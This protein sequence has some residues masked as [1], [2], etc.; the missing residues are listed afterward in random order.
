VPSTGLLTYVAE[1]N[2]P[3]I[4]TITASSPG[5]ASITTQVIL[6]A[7]DTITIVSTAPAIDYGR[8]ATISATCATGA[9]PTLSAK[10]TGKDIN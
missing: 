7:H 4:V 6:S 10:G 9:T 1:T 8:T 3:I 2:T 5:A